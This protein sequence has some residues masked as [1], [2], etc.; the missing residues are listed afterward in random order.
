VTGASALLLLFSIHIGLHLQHRRT[1]EAVN[2]ELW[3]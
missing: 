3:I 1:V 2:G